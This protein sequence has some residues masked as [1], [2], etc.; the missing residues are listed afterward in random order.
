MIAFNSRNSSGKWVILSVLQKLKLRFKEA[1]SFAV[2]RENRTENVCLTLEHMLI[3]LC[4]ASCCCLL[5][6]NELESSSRKFFLSL[7]KHQFLTVLEL[8]GKGSVIDF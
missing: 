5:I 8:E 7:T 3:E 6:P 1:H 4:L 2:I